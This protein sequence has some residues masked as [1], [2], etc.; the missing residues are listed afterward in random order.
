M[1]KVLPNGEVVDATNPLRVATSGSFNVSQPISDT[2][3]LPVAVDP[4][5]FNVGE[6]VSAT[7]RLPV[8]FVNDGDA[9]PTFVPGEPI[10]K[11][12]PMPIAI[13]PTLKANWKRGEAITGLR[14]VPGEQVVLAGTVEFSS[15]VIKHDSGLYTMDRN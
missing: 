5:T 8:V 2:N 9:V 1:V 6:P 14:P 13:G 3:L 11:S 7:N 15:G 12:N 4:P 10:S